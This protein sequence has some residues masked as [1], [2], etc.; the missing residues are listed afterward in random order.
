MGVLPDVK[1]LSIF[2]GLEVDQSRKQ[3]DHVPS[4]VHDRGSAVGTANLAWQL[5]NTGLLRALVPTQIVMAVGEID[6]VFVK[7]GRPLERCTFIASSEQARVSSIEKDR[8]VKFLAC[9]TMAVL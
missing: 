1:V 9:C 4:F 7:D 8:T 3:Q 5:V 6:V 2:G